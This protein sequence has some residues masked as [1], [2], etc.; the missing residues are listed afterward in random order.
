[1][2]EY[3]SVQDR[4]GGQ[5]PG[6]AVAVAISGGGHRAANFGIG[7]LLGLEELAR[8]DKLR[9]VLGEVDYLSTVSG[10][11]MAAGAYLSSLR[12]YTTFHGSPEGYSLAAAFSGDSAKLPLER[13]NTDPGLRGHLEHNYVSEILRGALAIATLGRWHRGDFLESCFDDNVLGREWRQRKTGAADASLR[14]S[15]VFVPRDGNQLPRVPYWAA[16]ATTFENTAIFPFTPDHLK[17]YQI[18]GWRHRLAKVAGERAGADRDRL[19]YSAPLALGLMASG[20]FPVALPAITLDSSMDPRNPYLHLLDGGL[21]DNL[22]VVTAVRMLRQDRAARKVLLVIDAYNG[23]LAPF[24]NTPAS[25]GMLATAGRV[26][27]GSLDAWRGRSRELTAALC[28]ADANGSAIHPVF[29]SFDDLA[30]CKDCAELERFGFTRDDLAGLKRAGLKVGPGA[31]PF[32]LARDVWTWYDLS[33][34]EQKLLLAIGRCVVHRKAK[35]IRAAM[36]WEP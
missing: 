16:N 1:M 24:S 2:S 11:G 10:G 4:P 28:A 21:A 6:L 8:R 14:L 17:L 18:R 32:S 35:E 29:L 19:P 30:D 23:P 13:Q 22:G 15:D 25:P 9:N 31:S 33:P 7:A 34:A 27:V 12:D 5:N 20:A 3:R 36:G 26:A